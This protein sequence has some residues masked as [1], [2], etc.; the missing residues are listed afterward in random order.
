MTADE[1]THLRATI[2][3]IDAQLLTLFNERAKHALKIAE[4]KAR[5]NEPILDQ[6]RE[7]NILNRLLKKNAGPLDADAIAHLFQTLLTESRRLQENG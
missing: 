6:T 4:I 5:K 1:L 7:N 3:E 2:D